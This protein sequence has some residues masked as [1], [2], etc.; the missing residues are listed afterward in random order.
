MQQVFVLYHVVL[1]SD[2]LE[3]LERVVGVYTTHEGAEQA[4]ERLK[5]KPGFKEHPNLIDYH[6]DKADFQGFSI[7]AYDL[8]K[9]YCPDGY[10]PEP[11]PE[12]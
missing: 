5:D 7:D 10:E 12:Q 3:E 2:G 1:V 6:S 4:I 11:L 9:D 8:N